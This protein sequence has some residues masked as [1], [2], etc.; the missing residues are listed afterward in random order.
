METSLHRD[1]KWLYAGEAAQCEVRLAGFRIDAVVDGELIEVQHGPLAAIR[2]KIRKLL[3]KHRV[4]VVKPIVARKLLVYRK[5]KGGRVARRR[6]SPKR[7]QLLDVFDELIHFTRVFPHPRLALEVPLVEIEEWRYPGHGRRRW[8]R[9]GDFQ[10]ED[11]KLI[12]IRSQHRLDT[13]NDLTAL[14]A[15]PLPAPFHTA[16]LAAGLSIPRWSAQRIAYC[17]HRMGALQQVGK[18]RNAWLYRWN[19]GVSL[20]GLTRLTG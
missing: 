1:L 17:L 5:R 2:D 20:A 13:I 9:D 7:G 6:L 14:V 4:R 12:E 8:R 19:D 16:H 3:E 11:Q 18:Q 10:V 15:C